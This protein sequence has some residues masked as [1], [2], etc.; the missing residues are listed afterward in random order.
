MYHYTFFPSFIDY[1]LFLFL[2]K[3]L[4]LSSIRFL[5]SL[6]YRFA[7][8]IATR[9]AYPPHLL[10]LLKSPKLET[11]CLNSTSN[12]TLINATKETSSTQDTVL[13]SRQR[14][15]CINRYATVIPGHPFRQVV[16]VPSE[17]ETFPSTWVPKD[18][19]FEE[20]AEADSHVFDQVREKDILGNSPTLKK[21]VI[22]T[23]PANHDGSVLN[24]L[25]SLDKGLEDIWSRCF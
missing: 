22:N 20:I 4:Q 3:S 5:F 14:L 15:R 19:N 8:T 6:L 11:R 21:I 23:N 12:I 25:R 9:L 10:T 16:G 24:T 1:F 7:I 13:G 17:E 18:L 2:A